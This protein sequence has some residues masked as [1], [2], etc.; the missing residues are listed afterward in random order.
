MTLPNTFLNSNG[1]SVDT[2]GFSPFR[3]ILSV[4][5]VY[6]VFSF[7]VHSFVFIFLPYCIPRTFRET[8]N[9]SGD[10][11]CVSIPFSGQSFQYF[12]IFNIFQY[13]FNIFNIS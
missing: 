1:V 5:N 4:D 13:I 2:P 7:P 10:G 9:R 3:I 12:T 6:F 11:I 8:L